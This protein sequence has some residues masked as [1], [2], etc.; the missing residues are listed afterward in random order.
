MG[1]PRLGAADNRTGLLIVSML[2]VQIGAGFAGRL[3]DDIGPAGAV[4]MRQGGAAI[5]L[6]AVSRPHS[7]EA[8]A[9]GRPSWRSG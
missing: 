4:M 7:A 6:L 5:V 2:S 3:I 8:R 9:N 1:A